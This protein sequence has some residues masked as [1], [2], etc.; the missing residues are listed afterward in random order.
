VVAAID[1]P[2]VGLGA[3]L[4]IAC[5][6]RVLGDNAAFAFP[7]LGR[8]LFPTNGV[9]ELLAKTVGLGRAM[10]MLLSGRTIGSDEAQAAGL[11]RVAGDA[12]VEAER[13]AGQVAGHDRAAVQLAVKALRGVSDHRL[14]YAL[15]VETAAALELAR[16]GR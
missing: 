2:A 6:L 10:E 14:S 4:A 8:G 13:L 1:G 5:D 11:G 3:E 16:R 7:E 12:L 15:G 9:T